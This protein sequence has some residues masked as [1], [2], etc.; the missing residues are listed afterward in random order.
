MVFNT[1]Q[2]LF[3]TNLKGESNN[4]PGGEAVFGT[5]V[6]PFFCFILRIM[7]QSFD[8]QKGRMFSP[9]SENPMDIDLICVL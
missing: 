3:I 9:S 1:N 7:A 4:L 2:R 5:K 6:D 8:V